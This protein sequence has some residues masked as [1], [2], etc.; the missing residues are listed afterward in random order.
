[1]KDAGRYVAWGRCAVCSDAVYKDSA[2]PLTED[3]SAEPGS[4]HGVMH[5]TREVALRQEFAGPVAAVRATLVY[6]LD[7][8]HNGY[9]PNRFRRLAAAGQEIVLFGEGEEQRDHV[10]VEDIAE[11]V[12]N[13]ILRRSAGIA[14]AVSGQVVSFNTLAQFAVKEFASKSVIRS[15]PRNGPMPH[16]GLRPFDNSAVL[17]AFPG[18]RFK[19][20]QEGLSAVHAQHIS[21]SKQ[22]KTQ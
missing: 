8:P 14:N 3:S 1:Q 21:Q 13:I 11:L 10:H 15:T 6:G 5:L 4:L 20:W 17:K 9:G 16:N 12:R 2:S 18:F 19:G 7:D 22:E